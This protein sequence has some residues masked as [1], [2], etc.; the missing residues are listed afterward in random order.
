MGQ[1]SVAQAH[2]MAPWAEGSG[3][4]VDPSV[5]G[6]L[7]DQVHGNVVAELTQNGEFRRGWKFGAFQD[8]S[9]DS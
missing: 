6:Q 7:R 1:L 3:L 8:L 2:D 4:F 5:P 9:C